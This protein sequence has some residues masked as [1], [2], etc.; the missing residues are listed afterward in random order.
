VPGRNLLKSGLLVAG[1]L[2]A[3][4]ANAGGA[5]IHAAE[6]A[7]AARL[8]GRQ[9]FSSVYETKAAVCGVVTSAGGD[10][11]FLVVVTKTAAGKPALGE[12]LLDASGGPTVTGADGRV[13]PLFDARWAEACV[14]P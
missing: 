13:T 7:V 14:A 5:D 12:V 10:Q 2:V 8:G 6:K 9:F 1:V 11:R 4:R 3:T